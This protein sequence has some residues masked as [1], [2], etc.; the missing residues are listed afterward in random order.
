MNVTNTPSAIANTI[1]KP[2]P[3]LSMKG[4]TKRTRGTW[5][6]T[7]TAAATHSRTQVP[8][9]AVADNWHNYCDPSGEGCLAPTLE[10]MVEEPKK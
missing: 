8:R 6:V 9:P 1:M 10:Q 7:K 2:K 4:L 5:S 3:G